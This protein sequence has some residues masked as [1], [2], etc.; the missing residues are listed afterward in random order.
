MAN[1]KELKKPV[2]VSMTETEK[3]KLSDKASKSGRSLSN[4]ILWVAL[5][6]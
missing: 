3:K 4:Y 5:N 1:K 6:A 2:S